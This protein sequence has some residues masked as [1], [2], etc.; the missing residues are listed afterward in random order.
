LKA[1]KT[2][3]SKNE[4]VIEQHLAGQAPLPGKKKYRDCAERIKRIVARYDNID[5]IDYL[6]GLAHN[7]NF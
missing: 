2:E 4:V 6:R 5:L 1:L 7:F 3:Q